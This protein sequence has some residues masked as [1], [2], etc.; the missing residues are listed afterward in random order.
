M[1]AQEDR[2]PLTD[3]ECR[4]MA[5]IVSDVTFVIVVAIMAVAVVIVCGCSTSLAY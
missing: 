4:L 5:R 3:A 1:A 2:E